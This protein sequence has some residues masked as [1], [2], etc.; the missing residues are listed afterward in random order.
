MQ[1]K[2]WLGRP[3]WRGTFFEVL[4]MVIWSVK[5]W[6][7]HD[8]TML[9]SRRER[10]FTST[11]WLRRRL[12]SGLCSSCLSQSGNESLSL[13]QLSMSK[14][15]VVW[16]AKQIFPRI[17]LLASLT[18]SRL[19]TLVRSALLPLVKIN[20]VFCWTDSTTALHWIKGVYKEYK[21]FVENKVKEIRQ[22]VPPEAWNHCPE[23]QNP[24]DL[25][26][27]GMGSDAL[28]QSRLWWHGP[29]WLVKEKKIWPFFGNSHEP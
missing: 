15:R 22:N 10:N 11:T 19:I 27:R 7:H 25:P 6:M 24:A 17:E 2:N 21:Q 18:L 16:L 14:S 13:V 5:S 28:K 29:F 1:I 4:A 12:W 3:S 23:S 26:F 8:L 20:E 9:S